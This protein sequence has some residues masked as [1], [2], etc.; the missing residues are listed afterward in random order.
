M[1]LLPKDIDK[2]CAMWNLNNGDWSDAPEFF[3]VSN[4]N[5]AHIYYIFCKNDRERLEMDQKPTYKE[6]QQ[7]V[8]ELE[9]KILREG[10]RL[11]D[12]LNQADGNNTQRLHQAL[13]AIPGF[14][15]LQ[16]QDYSIAFANKKFKEI[17]GEPGKRPCY[18][19]CWGRS[20]PCEVCPTFRVF[21]TGI[22]EQWEWKSPNGRYFLLYD[23]LFPGVGNE[24]AM[25]IEIGIDITERK[26][27][28]EAL[29]ESEERYR[30]M[31]DAMN[32]PAYI[33]SEDFR[34]EYMNSAMKKRITKDAIGEAC[35]FAIHNFEKKC[36]WC[37]YN[38]IKNG[39]K[40]ELEINSPKDNHTFIV[41][42]APIYKVDGSIAMI[43]IFTD[44]T[45]RKQAEK[46]LLESTK[47][48]EF[49]AD[50][51]EKAHQPIAIGYPDGR[52]GFCNPAFCELTGYTVNEL[53]TMDWAKVLTPAEWLPSE[54]QVLKEL[55]R[56]GKPV[57]YEKEYIRKDGSR[58]PID[59]LVHLV[60]NQGDESHYYYA[61]ITDT[62]E[63]KHAEKKIK[64]S[65]KL[66]KE[67][68][69]VAHIG[70]WELD[71]PSG[72]PIWSE[73]IFRIFGVDSDK[74]APSFS[75]HRKIVHP[76]DWPQ[77]ENAI[78]KL[79]SDGTPFNFQ[80]RI[81]RSNKK[82]GWMNAIGKAEKNE[83]GEVTRMFGTAQDISELKKVEEQLERT[84][85]Q[86]ELAMK[87]ANDGL[88]DWNLETNKIYYS[89]GWKKIL[90]YE[91]HEIKNEFSE[92]ERLTDPEDVKASWD[93]L[94][95]LLNGKREK[96][97]KEFKMLHKDGHWVNILSRAN[98]IF[99]EKGKGKR[100]VGTHIDIS[101]RKRAEKALRESEAQFRH[102][103]EHLAIGIAVYEVVGD[104]E[105]FIISDMNVTGQQLS[106]V[107]IDAIR[108]KKITEVFPGVKKLGL[109]K[110][111]QNTWQYGKPCHI[112]HQKYEDE[113]IQ[114]WVENRV[115]K[116]PSGQIVAVYE[117]RTEFIRIEEN[118][119]QAQKM[120][121]VG[122]LAGGIAHDFNNML[123]IIYGN[124]SYLLNRYKKDEELVEVLSDIQKG[125]QKSQQ[126]TQQ[127]LTFAK[128]GAPIKKAAD[129]NFIIKESAK[130]VTRGA[131]VK[132]NFDF[133][134]NLWVAEVDSGQLNQVISNLV[135][136]ANQ[137]MPT[138]GII[139]I[140]SENIEIEAESNI[141]LTNG[142]YVKIILEDQGIGI[143]E[144]HLQNIFDPYF[145]TKQEGSGLGLATAYSII[146]KHGGHIGVES[147]I[148]EGTKFS[149][150][151]PVSEKH[152]LK[153][154]E[155]ETCRHVG[156]GRILVMDDE[157]HILKMAGR[158]LS[159]MG[160]EHRFAKDGAEAVET[161]QTKFQ[162]QNPFDLVIL[163]LTVPGGMGGQETIKEL[164]KI[165]TDVKAIVSSGY[166]ND[167]VMS[168]YKEY[169]FCG[170]IPKPYSQEEVA[171][172]FNEILGKK[173]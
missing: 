125:A 170:V 1:T 136:N 168:N 7:R 173:G 73:E 5:N 113:R 34:V 91:E 167:P 105:D 76:E 54:M 17:F 78:T 35:Y 10:K 115:F 47:K 117:D 110:A 19:V 164:L 145:S 165:D 106:K 65:E 107:S 104:G 140:K 151:L 33:C 4:K 169:G 21:E 111:L 11:E 116:L 46:E 152:I 53:K 16:A 134:D 109:F 63:R 29:K 101:D 96:F 13:D 93:M 84:K 133:A 150:Y 59:M 14:V 162:S 143:S 128:G 58:V 157:E 102:Y 146:R 138:G 141:P 38:E 139:T 51:I 171:K 158:M 85:E 22:P 121:A 18:E 42:S 153:I 26:Q 80:F 86:Y 135:I 120:E 62:T 55:E 142:K 137:A 89:P 61:F 64:K 12:Y 41:S 147:K 57:Q 114:L 92:W 87:F 75:D 161:Y 50:I 118:L 25:V 30:S 83:T 82:I 71:S 112:P 132:C 99:D 97:E 160:Y 130:F 40:T 81:L 88:F 124:V 166:S 56:T 127:L 20:E 36:S 49:L 28:E 72:T 90:G 60:S 156:R 103:F 159:E 32:H 74:D 119:H 68:Q 148:D 31:M 45:D 149:I 108:G 144:K 8:R 23:E 2:E 131:K 48:I 163:D 66:H 39:N 129:I 43:N 24:D 27:A 44:I 154:D 15:Y 95:E 79:S 100:V 3:D 67:A 123:G 172:V 94:N 69:A 98:V 155:K 70:H 52:L 77:L 126:L 6:L 37:Q 9:Q 122:M